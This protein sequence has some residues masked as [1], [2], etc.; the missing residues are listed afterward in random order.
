MF[1]PFHVFSFHLWMELLKNKAID[2]GRKP[3]EVR[4]NPDNV[5]KNIWV[6]ANRATKACIIMQRT[7]KLLHHRMRT[8]QSIIDGPQ[9]HSAKF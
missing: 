5:W 9:I 6:K 3:R 1:V 4:S 2:P 8:T 7:K